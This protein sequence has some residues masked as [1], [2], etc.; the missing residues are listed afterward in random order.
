MIIRVDFLIF[1][2]YFLFLRNYRHAGLSRALIFTPF[3]FGLVFNSL[4]VQRSFGNRFQL[5]AATGVHCHLL[6]TLVPCPC[7]D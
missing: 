5:S 2:N 6:H 4:T 7:K 1:F 3:C